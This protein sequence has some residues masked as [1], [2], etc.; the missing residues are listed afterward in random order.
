MRSRDRDHPGQHGETPSLLKTQKLAKHGD[1]DVGVR[2][3]EIRSEHSFIRA[4]QKNRELGC[5]TSLKMRKRHQHSK[6]HL[7]T[8]SEYQKA[9]LGHEH[10]CQGACLVSIR[11]LPSDM[12]ERKLG[13]PVLAAP[14]CTCLSRSCRGLGSE[15]TSHLSTPPGVRAPR[16]HTAGA[17]QA[18]G[19]FALSP[20]SEYN[21]VIMAFCSLDLTGSSNPPTPA[22]HVAGTTDV[23]HHSQLIIIIIICRDGIS[24][25]CPGWGNLRADGT[26]GKDP[27]IINKQPPEL[28]EGSIIKQPAYL[29]IRKGA[30][31]EISTNTVQALVETRFHHVGQAGLKLLTSSDPAHLGFPKCWDYRQLTKYMAAPVK[32]NWL[33]R[34]WWLM[35][36]IPALWEAEKGRSRGQEL[37]ISLTN[38]VKPIS[39]EKTKISWMCHVSGEV[40]IPLLTSA[41]LGTHHEQ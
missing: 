34:V 15:H 13:D 24:L 9:G 8:C 19:A 14:V 16:K 20:R 28:F 29:S 38:I 32:N 26:P 12:Q 22:S 4:L 33:S 25:C 30:G 36:T 6:K 27:S 1:Y 41:T 17:Q 3:V 18:L 11:G 23:Y 37:E 2:G 5:L 40:G 31:I 35:P 21:G 39:T 7:N 10:R